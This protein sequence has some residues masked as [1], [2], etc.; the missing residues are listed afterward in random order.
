MCRGA[1]VAGVLTIVFAAGCTQGSVKLEDQDKFGGVKSAVW[2]EMTQETNDDDY[3]S[4]SFVMSNKRGLCKSMQEAMP[5]AAAAG[6]DFLEDL[7]YESSSSSSYYLTYG[8]DTGGYYT[9][10]TGG[11]TS[12]LEDICD[13]YKTYYERLGVAFDGL[14]GEGVNNLSLYL[15]DPDDDSDDEPPSD[16]YEAG[17]DEDDPFFTGSLTYYESNP[18]QLIGEALD[19]G[20]SDWYEEASEAGEDAFDD[21]E[22]FYI[23]DGDLVAEQTSNDEAYKITMDGDL[24]DD[25]GDNEGDIE[26]KGKFKKCEVEFDGYV[27]L[28]F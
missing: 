10:P 23:D 28:Y 27:Y 6:E 21:I 13:A 2:F 26:I 1:W 25:D 4:H 24:E 19:C 18:Y 11:S 16:E 12:Y 7:G 8:A 22:V 14:Y 5:E 20:D 17:Y 3:T 9:G 15:R